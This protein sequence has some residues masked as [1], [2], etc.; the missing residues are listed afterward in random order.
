V[1]GHVCPDPRLVAYRLDII[2]PYLI[3]AESAQPALWQEGLKKLR[4]CDESESPWCTVSPEELEAKALGR[5]FFREVRS[6]FYEDDDGADGDSDESGPLSPKFRWLAYQ[7][8]AGDAQAQSHLPDLSSFG[9]G[10]L[11]RRVSGKEATIGIRFPSQRLSIQAT[12]LASAAGV[13]FL[14]FRLSCRKSLSLSDGM[15]INYLGSHGDPADKTLV[16]VPSSVKGSMSRRRHES[17]ADKDSP[18]LPTPD[19][20]AQCL[21]LW[22]E[23]EPSR[24]PLPVIGRSLPRLLNDSIRREMGGVRTYAASHGRLPVASNLLLPW[25]DGNDRS[26]TPGHFVDSQMEELE[27]LIARCHRHPATSEVVPLPLDHLHGPEFRTIH[28]TGS[29]RFHVTNEGFHAFGLARTGFDESQWPDRTGKEYFL[30]YLIALHQAVV[31]QGL[32]WRSYNRS[33]VSDQTEQV[34]EDFLQYNTEY[35]FSV[36]SPQFN[37]QRLYRTSREV[38]GV[39]QTGEEVHSELSG[40]AENETRKE[41]G[42]LNSLAVLAF[43]IGFATFFTGLNFHYFNQ[44]SQ[45]SLFWGDEGQ[46]PGLLFVWLPAAVVIVLAV[47][48]R[49]L[50]E[51]LRR[52]WRMLWK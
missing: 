7:N 11:N 29:Q 18:L 47:V 20:L 10:I 22:P 17:G 16:L 6:L 27:G 24:G 49:P 1:S 44:D 33:G 42:N 2:Y 43:L 12:A 8:P 52:V 25:A 21:T 41:Q 30:T 19:E 36:V 48:R 46:A 26:Q 50:R 34:Y 31:I 35:D 51:H 38:L 37:I 28:I 5:W 9:V 3:R 13:L 39:P 4:K 15:L 40:W 32:S 45:M 14:N 23:D